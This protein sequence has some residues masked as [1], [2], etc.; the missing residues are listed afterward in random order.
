MP[1]GL[2]A[3]WPPG[4]LASWPPGLLASSGLLASWPPGSGP[5]RV[6]PDAS[7]R[8]DRRGRLTVLPRRVTHPGLRGKQL[9]W[10]RAAA[11]PHSYSFGLLTMRV[12][13]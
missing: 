12:P 13:S 10:V 5:I 3:S 7:E 9:K 4:L 11:E 8:R 2:L 6:P 1:P